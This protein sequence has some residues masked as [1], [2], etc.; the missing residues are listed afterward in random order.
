MKR[1]LCLYT[2]GTLGC[3]PSQQGLAP[4]P[5]ILN[6]PIAELAAHLPGSPRVELLEYPQLLDSSSMGPADW[7]RIGA[8]IAGHHADYDGFVVLH[9]TDT[10][11]YTAA[12]LSFQ[13]EHLAKPVIVTGAQRPW[14]MADSDAPANVS[15]ALEHALGDWPG[16]RVAFGGRLLP[17]ARV[18]KTDADNNQAFSA[19][20]WDGQWPTPV[21]PTTPARCFTIDPQARII[22]IK[23]YPGL[24]GDWLATALTQPQQGIVLETYGSGNLPEHAGLIAALEQQARAGAII[25]N[26][27][28]CLAGHVQQGHYA[29]SSSLQRIRALPAADM[30]PEAALTKLYYLQATSATANEI[31]E[32]FVQNL[33]GELTPD[34]C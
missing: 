15:A 22:G 21:A 16:V 18:R 25:V 34:L 32:N 13:L 19:P 20:N 23:L 10:L 27:T 3:L 14:F 29:T 24:T 31:R 7:N 5:G 26:C 11:A 12:A 1:I 17:G 28:Q 6:T 33:R 9:G 4:A 30:T 8:D 2:G